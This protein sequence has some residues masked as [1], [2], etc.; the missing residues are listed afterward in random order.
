MYISNDYSRS[1]ENQNGYRT[2]ILRS[3]KSSQS[4]KKEY[5]CGKVKEKEY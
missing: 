1:T 5:A 4:F 2:R 3:V